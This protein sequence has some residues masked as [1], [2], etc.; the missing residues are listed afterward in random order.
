MVQSGD[1]DHLLPGQGPGGRSA[2]T[3]AV[4]GYDGQV[5]GALARVACRMSSAGAR[6]SRTVTPG[7]VLLAT[8]SVPTRRT[9]D[10]GA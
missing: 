9:C 5:R 4:Q 8:A 10:T 6:R 3:G 1:Q 7:C 2:L